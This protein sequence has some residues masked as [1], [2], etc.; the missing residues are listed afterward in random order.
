MLHVSEPQYAAAARLSKRLFDIVGASLLLVAAAPLFVATAIAVKV[1]SP[2][3]VFYRQERIGRNSERFG[4]IKFR[5]MRSDADSQLA[6]LLKAEG[7]S[8]AELPKLTRDPRVTRVGSFIRRFS[9]DELPQLLNVVKG[10]MSLVGPRPQRDFEVAQYDRLAERRLTVRP[11][12]TGLWQVSG[13]SD[14]AYAE[15]ISLDVHYVENWSMVSDLMIL[16]RTARAV[17]ASEGAY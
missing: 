4:M 11:G 9:I 13:R 6:A 15:A 7:K 8:L 14:L 3:R 10:D 1:S 5:S 2:G 17:V 16:W 12:M